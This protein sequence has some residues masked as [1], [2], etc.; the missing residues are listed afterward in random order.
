LIATEPPTPTESQDTPTEA[1]AHEVPRPCRMRMQVV[2]GPDLG[3]D[4]KLEAG[5]YFIGKGHACDLILSD[6]AVS[7][8]HLEV[9]VLADGVQ[10][11]DLG[12]TNGSFAGGARFESVHAVAGAIIH[13]GQTEL[14][15]T[16]DD[17]AASSTPVAGWPIDE[18]PERFGPMVSANL[19]MRRVLALLER[20]APTDVA[21]LV[22]GE[23]GTGKEVVAEA[24]H[25]GSAR[26]NGPFV[27]CDL[28]SLTRSLIES[29]LFG[30][31][32]GAFTGADRDR[33]G[34]FAAADGGTLFLDE[35]GELKL[36]AQPRLLRAIERRQFKP[37]GSST[38]ETS[39]VRV[40][41][42]TNRDLLAE[43]RAGRFREDLYHRLAVM[44]VSLPPL[45]ERREDIPELVSFFLEQ[46]AQASG[47]RAP[48]IAPEAMVAL[49]AHD[50]P[51]NIRELRNVLE[52]AT[53]LKSEG[54]TVDL[55]LLGLEE[56]RSDVSTP[57]VDINFPFKEAKDALIQA[58]ER[59]Y[60]SALMAKHEGNVS[61]AA[62]SGGLDRVYLHR[63]LKKHNLGG[64]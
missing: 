27:V 11:R 19:N 2:T 10:I 8:R 44:R 31:V 46:A 15:L 64:V 35:I 37:V 62:R 12:S 17:P 6:H 56:T 30:H 36:D 14:L 48:V 58:W 51:G 21:V 13:I 41:A 45:R 47:R 49:R 3:R 20:A 61:S 42:A 39:D 32:R 22:Q 4:L 24:I 18:L 23:T 16:L 54:A 59:E 28:G 7:R 9:A 60:V 40:I 25:G 57:P 29:E 55:H 1:L 43:V 5:T 52:R 50:W 34:A 38:Y 33:Q 53:A 63:L 26:K